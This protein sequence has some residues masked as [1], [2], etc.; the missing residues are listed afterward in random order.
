MPARAAAPFPRVGYYISRIDAG[1]T[2]GLELHEETMQTRKRLRG[3]DARVSPNT[4]EVT[5]AAAPMSFERLET[6]APTG[7]LVS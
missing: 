5:L 7:A 1:R 6:A 2:V 4:D 3:R